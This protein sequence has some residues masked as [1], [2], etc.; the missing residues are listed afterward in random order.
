MGLGMYVTMVIVVAVIGNYSWPIISKQRLAANRTYSLNSLI[1]LG[2]ALQEFHSEY[3][4]FPDESTAATVKSA[5]ETPL[6]LTGNS[7]NRIF[8]QLIATG[9]R[10]EDVF[11]TPRPGFRRGDDHFEDDAHA[12]APGENG[13]AYMTS[14]NSNEWDS[15]TILALAPLIQGTTHCDPQ[16]FGAK[17]VIL[18]LDNSVSA[19]PIRPDGQVSAGEGRTIF[20]PGQL[21]WKGHPPVIHWCEEPVKS[22]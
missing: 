3:G 2:L 10:T 21:Y 13:F 19:L 1:G 22:K 9:C 16:P 7:S 11:Y 6:D 15:P 4:V 8:R 14:D 17:A 20:D 5:T 12:L 18:R